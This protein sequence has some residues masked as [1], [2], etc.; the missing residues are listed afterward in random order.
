MIKQTILDA[1][2]N[3]SKTDKESLIDT[4]YND[5]IKKTEKEKIETEKE[6]I[7]KVKKTSKSILLKVKSL[8]AKKTK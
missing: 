2:K 6:K 3:I 4:E 7:K 5:P 8:T 1:Q